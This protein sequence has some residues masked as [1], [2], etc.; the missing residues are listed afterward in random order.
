M[1]I[2]R[3]L[4][5]A[6]LFVLLLAAAS[7]A[8]QTGSIKGKVRIE[9][10]AG[11][12]G[13]AVI[14]RQND[15]EVT[16]TE[17]NRKGDFTI[18]GLAPGTYG[19]TFR[20]TGLSV[21]TIENLDV[22][23]GKVRALRDHLIL[24]VDEGSIASLQGSV[25]DAQG[26]SVRGTRVELLRVAADGTTKKLNERLTGESGEFT[27][28]LAPDKATYRITVKA[29]GAAAATKDVDVDG[30]AIYRVSL[31]IQPATKNKS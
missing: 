30:A 2:S 22:R 31:S 28:R 3:K 26:L 9:S 14:A 25:F 12:A 8:Q 16:R 10:G 23:A 17:T 24:T 1:T 6:S 15:R 7:L 18:N 5:G 20:R 29:E 4:I 21:G 19:L 27:F 11:A 13:V